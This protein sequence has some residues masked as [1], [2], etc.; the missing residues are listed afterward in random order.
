MAHGSRTLLVWAL[1]AAVQ[2]SACKREERRFQES[3]EGS[4]LRSAS[5]IA[6]GRD[7]DNLRRY[8]ENAWAISEGQRLYGQMNCSGCHGHG[9]G[10]SAPPLMDS[11]WLYGDSLEDIERSITFGRPRGMP[12][13]ES[14]LSPQQIWELVAFVRSLGGAAPTAAA[15]ARDD[16]MAVRPPPSRTEAQPPVKQRLDQ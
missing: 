12:A 13:F 8:S 7:R 16:H 9:G 6:S 14:R 1:F 2:S 3:P 15:P 10:G 5:A 11:K 4:R